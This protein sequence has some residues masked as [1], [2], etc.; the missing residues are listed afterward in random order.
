MTRHAAAS[1][2]I[3]AAPHATAPKA[4]PKLPNTY[5]YYICIQGVEEYK[6]KIDIDRI[7]HRT[8]GGTPGLI[9]K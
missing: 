5:T 9:T 4:N 8:E 3:N 1:I 7:F 6:T 2:T